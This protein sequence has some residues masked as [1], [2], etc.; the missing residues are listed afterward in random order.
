MRSLIKMSLF[1][2]VFTILS[3]QTRYQVVVDTLILD[4]TV[5]ESGYDFDGG[6]GAYDE[7]EVISNSYRI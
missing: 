7:T 4:L 5:E 6:L 1:F 2:V 3:A